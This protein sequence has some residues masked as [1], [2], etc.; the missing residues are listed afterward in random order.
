MERHDHL[1]SV[2]PGDGLMRTVYAKHL[3]YDDGHLGE[4]VAEMRQIG[5]PTLRVMDHRGA[6]M[7][8]EGSHRLAAAHHLGI[9]PKLVVEVSDVPGDLCAHWDVVASD[10]PS[11]DFDAVLVLDLRGFL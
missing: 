4:V 3:P 1:E 10:L 2:V 11:Y 8:T 9:V 7:A 6:L 5:A